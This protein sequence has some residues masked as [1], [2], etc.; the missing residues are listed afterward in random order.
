[1]P[2][3]LAESFPDLTTRSHDIQKANKSQEERRSARKANMNIPTLLESI[4]HTSEFQ[5][6]QEKPA[7]ECR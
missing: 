1:M 3:P 2:E 6:I 5:S 7:E 4:Q